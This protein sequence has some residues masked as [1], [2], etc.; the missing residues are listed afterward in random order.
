MVK[1][2]APT[3]EDAYENFKARNVQ[4]MLALSQSMLWG[5]LIRTHVLWL[6]VKN[7]GS[8]LAFV[9]LPE[10]F[11]LRELAGTALDAVFKANS[12]FWEACPDQHKKDRIAH[13]VWNFEAV[14]GDDAICSTNQFLGSGIGSGQ[15][16]EQ[17]GHTAQNRGFCHNLMR[18]MS[19]KE[20]SIAR[21]K[22]TAATVLDSLPEF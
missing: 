15:P 2:I 4:D 10:V 11:A 1:E 17:Y 13:I 8:G 16:L 19:I 7:I 3:N 5:D 6:N 21:I 20:I 18:G 14:E 22:G 12:Q 9:S